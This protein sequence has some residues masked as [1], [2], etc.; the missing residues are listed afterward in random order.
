MIMFIQI[1]KYFQ[2][3]KIFNLSKMTMI[4]LTIMVKSIR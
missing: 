4:K 2:Q 3:K 1:K